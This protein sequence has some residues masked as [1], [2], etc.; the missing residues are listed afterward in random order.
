[1]VHGS[2]IQKYVF[3]QLNSSISQLHAWLKRYKPDFGLQSQP[4]RGRQIAPHPVAKRVLNM[5]AGNEVEWT[6]QIT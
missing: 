6:L 3:L 5:A 1:M 4:G 2:M